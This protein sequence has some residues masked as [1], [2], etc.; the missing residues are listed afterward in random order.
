MMPYIKLKKMAETIMHVFENKHNN[1]F[2]HKKQRFVRRSGPVQA[3]VL[4][5]EYMKNLCL[6][7]LFFS[8]YKIINYRHKD[9]VDYH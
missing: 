8:V 2:I 9:K 1:I 6:M 5:G 3:A 4:K 7:P